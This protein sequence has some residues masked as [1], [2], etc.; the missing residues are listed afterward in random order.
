[1]DEE[2]EWII[3]LQRNDD[4]ALE[5][6]YNRLSGNVFALAKQ[7]LWSREDAEEIVQDTFV[8]VYESAHRFDPGRGSARAWVYTIARNACKMRLRRKGSRPQKQLGVDMHEPGLPIAAPRMGASHV[9]RLTV[10]AAFDHLEEED[11]EF[12]QASFFDG[13]S[14]GEIADRTGTP[15][16][17]VKSRIRR[18][19]LKV[20]DFLGD[21]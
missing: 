1:M 12:L 4:R 7:M 20:R 15:L 3:R 8:S 6:L 10:Q 13:Y 19:L 2:A 9:D 17:T 21:S 14:H 16:G 11:V 18:A 5:E